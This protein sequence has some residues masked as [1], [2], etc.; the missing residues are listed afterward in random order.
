MDRCLLTS[1]KTVVEGRSLCVSLNGIGRKGLKDHSDTMRP[2]CGEDQ[3]ILHF[4]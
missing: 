2:L 4:Y 1:L 3:I